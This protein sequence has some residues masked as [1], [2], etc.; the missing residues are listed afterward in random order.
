MPLSKSDYLKIVAI[1]IAVIVTIGVIE[2]AYGY[3]V[4]GPRAIDEAYATA[5]KNLETW[6][7]KEGI[8]N[9]VDIYQYYQM[10]NDL[11]DSYGKPHPYQPTPEPTLRGSL[12]TNGVKVTDFTYRRDLTK[13]SEGVINGSITITY[14]GE[15]DITNLTLSID[16]GIAHYFNGL[17]KGWQQTFQVS[18]KIDPDPALNP[19]YV[20]DTTIN[21]QVNGQRL[22]SI[23]LTWYG[24]ETHTELGDSYP[25]SIFKL[26]VN[27][28]LAYNNTYVVIVDIEEYSTWATSQSPWHLDFTVGSYTIPL[29]SQEN[30]HPIVY[31]CNI[32]KTEDT[33]LLVL[34]G[35]SKDVT[36]PLY[37]DAET[38]EYTVEL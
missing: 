23:L 27:T 33:N 34:H 29:N 36:L 21:I 37:F 11:A 31:A 35:D 8:K 30:V 6:W 7:H 20:P 5:S 4:V 13:N 3:Y 1:V 24:T 22:G 32:V 14:T 15:Q 10:Q 38:R 25:S 12:D 28:A 2:F 18:Y 26:S 16:D 19:L 17:A 9:G